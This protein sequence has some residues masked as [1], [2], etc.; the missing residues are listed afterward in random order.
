MRSQIKK[1]KCTIE[2]ISLPLDL[3]QN[4]LDWL[5]QQFRKYNLRWLLAHADDGVIW[6]EMR[7][8]GL[9]LSSKPFPEASPSLRYITLKEARLFNENTEMHLWNDGQTLKGTLIKEDDGYE[10]ECYDESYLLWGN[11][12]EKTEDGFTLVFQ[13]SEGLC[14]A[15]PIGIDE[16]LQF[17]IN[18]KV[19]HF[20]DYDSDGQAFIAFS[21]L[22]S[23]YCSTEE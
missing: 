12:E 1:V 22:V 5:L 15:P 14:H 16:E 4:F 11:R 3:H 13:G 18:I 21:R 19:R 10:A 8:D 2:S 6:G 7:Q 17:Q 9:H 20:L 23:L